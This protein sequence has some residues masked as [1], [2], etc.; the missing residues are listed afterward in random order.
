MLSLIIGRDWPALWWILSGLVADSELFMFGSIW[1]ATRSD[2]TSISAHMFGSIRCT[3]S[4][5]FSQ[6]TSPRSSSNASWFG[7]ARKEIQM[8][9]RPKRWS[10][11]LT[12]TRKGL[13]D[14]AMWQKYTKWNN[15]PSTKSTQTKITALFPIVRQVS[16]NSILHFFHGFEIKEC[17]KNTK[18]KGH[19]FLLQPQS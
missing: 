9:N 18:T 1:K 17:K 12:G 19:I 10:N 15:S 11:R 4:R 3:N 5:T 2:V 16:R 14:L 6:A 8:G 13:S 7:E